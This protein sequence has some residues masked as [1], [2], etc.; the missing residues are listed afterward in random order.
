MSLGIKFGQ[1][2]ENSCVG[3]SADLAEMGAQLCCDVGD[4]SPAVGTEIVV[5]HPEVGRVRAGHHSSLVR[6]VC[7]QA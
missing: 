1:F 4:E 7:T 3:G 6:V 2:D 5:E